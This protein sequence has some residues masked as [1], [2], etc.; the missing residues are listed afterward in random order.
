MM[1]RSSGAIRSR[2]QPRAW[3]AISSVEPVPLSLHTLGQLAGEWAGRPDQLV[4]GTAGDVA[5]IAGEDC[6]PALV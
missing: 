6:V 2:S 5:L 4:E 1:F 3:R